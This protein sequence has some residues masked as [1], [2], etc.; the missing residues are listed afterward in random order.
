M[1]NILTK[2]SDPDNL[3][4]VPVLTVNISPDVFREVI[5]LVEAGT[6]SDPEQFLSVAVFNQVALEKGADQQRKY[7]EISSSRADDMRNEP[8]GRSRTSS[9]L[10]L[11]PKDV[12]VTR[13]AIRDTLSRMNCSGYS[14]LALSCAPFCEPNRDDRLWGQVNRL[15]PVKVLCRWIGTYGAVYGEWP[16][17]KTVID[18]IPPDAATLGSYLETLDHR[19][20]RSREEALSTGLPRL[21]NPASSDRFASQ[22]I[23]RVTRANRVH[24][25]AA[26]QLLFCSLQGEHIVLTNPGFELARLENPILDTEIDSVERTLSLEECAF[27]VQHLRTAVICEWNDSMSVLDAIRDGHTSP[28]GLLS[29]V[30]R[31]FPNE[32]SDMAYRTHVYGILARLSELKFLERTWRGRNVRYR[33]AESA[34]DVIQNEWSSS[35]TA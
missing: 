1:G 8:T 22:C 13:E 6:Y 15:F 28:T 29:Y 21:A 32:W 27:F 9:K 25:G 5:R 14:K 31:S 34:H 16:R 35:Q 4:S 24:P 12:V 19:A 7:P 20:D 3:A 23:A 11:P 2:K 10:A 33:L 30:R 26:V 18:K 17:L